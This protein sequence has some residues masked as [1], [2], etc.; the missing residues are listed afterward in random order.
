MCNCRGFMGFDGLKCGTVVNLW[1]RMFENVKLWKKL[2]KSIHQITTCEKNKTL[3]VN[4]RLVLMVQRSSGHI[5][6]ELA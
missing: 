6:F 1:A 5:K 3:P 4:G 2:V